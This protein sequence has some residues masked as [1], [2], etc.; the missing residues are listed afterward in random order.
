[1]QILELDNTPYSCFMV[2]VD[3]QESALFT[4]YPKKS[5]GELR[6]VTSDMSRCHCIEMKT[7]RMDKLM[8]PIPSSPGPFRMISV[9]Q[10]WYV[11]GQGMFTELYDFNSGLSNILHHSRVITSCLII[12]T[13]L[14]F[15]PHLGY[16]LA[17]LSI[18][19][20]SCLRSVDKKQT[21]S[22]T[23]KHIQIKRVLFHCDSW[24]S[25]R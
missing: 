24:P 20:L 3:H 4:A 21:E 22:H 16:N 1:M 18:D 19:P 14:Q 8:N 25:C 23:E 7:R 9:H 2:F 11:T 5:D 15:S 13:Y 17:T 12:T 6:T 10:W